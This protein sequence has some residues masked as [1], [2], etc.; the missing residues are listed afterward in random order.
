[1]A[2]FKISGL[3]EASASD[4]DEFIFDTGGGVYKKITAENA[5]IYPK[6]IVLSISGATSIDLSSYG[7]NVN[8]KI[9]LTANS[10][11]LFT[12]MTAGQT[13]YMTIIQDGSSAY[14]LS[15]S[16]TAYGDTLAEPAL[17]TVDLVSYVMTGI[18]AVNAAVP[19]FGI[20]T[21]ITA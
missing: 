1:M 21:D 5:G 19:V 10:T 17:G 12:N 6:E 9:T 11:L 20:K 18:G 8:F 7:R 16:G 15:Y 4:S 14:T 3:T 13:G 2:D